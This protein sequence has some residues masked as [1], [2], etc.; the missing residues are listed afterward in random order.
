MRLKHMSQIKYC[1][2][3][4]IGSTKPY[5]GEPCFQSAFPYL[6]QCYNA[7][8]TKQLA[9]A[10]RIIRKL[11]D[12]QQDTIARQLIRL[13]DLAELSNIELASASGTGFS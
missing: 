10:I 11:P 4:N 6:G 2:T 13:I 8:M 5:F 12:D 1:A 3:L 9:E 7:H